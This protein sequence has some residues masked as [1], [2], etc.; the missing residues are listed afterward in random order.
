MR[1]MVVEADTLSA[2]QLSDALTDAGFN[3]VGRARSSG[4]A[5]L[6]ARSESPDIVVFGMDLE[7]CGAGRHLA[8]KLEH[9]LKMPAL[10]SSR[11]VDAHER[12]NYE[13]VVEAAVQLRSRRREDTRRTDADRYDKRY[14][15]SSTGRIVA[16]VLSV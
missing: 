2:L 11:H 13:A 5:F 14:E 6:L 7:A 10:L 8:D 3:V 12:A 1:A 4:E 16:S 9:E 15:A